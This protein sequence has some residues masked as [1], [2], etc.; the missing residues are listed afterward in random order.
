[1][2]YIFLKAGVLRGVR[3]K[4][5]SSALIPNLRCFSRLEVLPDPLHQVTR[6]TP[7]R[8]LLQLIRYLFLRVCLEI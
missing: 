7:L 4:K 2:T 3:K 5:Q 6:L 1:M 8:S